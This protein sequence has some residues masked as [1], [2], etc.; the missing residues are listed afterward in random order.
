MLKEKVQVAITAALALTATWIRRACFADAAKSLDHG[1]FRRV[2]EQVSLYP[3]ENVIR[4]ISGQ[5]QHSSRELRGL[6]K[7]HNVVRTTLW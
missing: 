6:D 7:Y 2:R 3:P 1:A 4:R 5:L